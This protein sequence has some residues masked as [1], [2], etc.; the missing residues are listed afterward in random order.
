MAGPNR[1]YYVDIKFPPVALPSSLQSTLP[2]DFENGEHAT[3]RMHLDESFWVV[4]QNDPA[5]SRLLTRY[6]GGP[7]GGLRGGCQQSAYRSHFVIGI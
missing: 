4:K 2:G 7:K 1:I 3:I 5:S 6:F